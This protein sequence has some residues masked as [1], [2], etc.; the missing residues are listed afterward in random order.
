MG[1]NETRSILVA[2]LVGCLLAAAIVVAGRLLSTTNAIQQQRY[3]ACVDQNHRHD[4]TVATLHSIL[5]AA[6]KKTPKQ[7]KQIAASEAPTL[8]LINALAPRQD[9]AQVV[10]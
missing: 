2:L 7:A 6:E 10:H 4:A 1:S 8:L 9:C 3:Q 5:S